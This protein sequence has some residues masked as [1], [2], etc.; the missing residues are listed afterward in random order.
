[1]EPLKCFFFKIFQDLPMPGFRDMPSSNAM[2]PE[3]HLYT[4]ENSKNVKVSVS[5][6][7]VQA[8]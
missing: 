7:Y 4:L 1:M 5:Y 2:T 8:A 6:K 3:S